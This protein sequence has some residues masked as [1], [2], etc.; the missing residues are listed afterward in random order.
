MLVD[1]FNFFGIDVVKKFYEIMLSIDMIFYKLVG[2]MFNIFSILSDTRVLSSDM[3][4]GLTTR[5]YA[6]ISVIMLF[7]LAYTFVRYLFNPDLANSGTTS[8]KTMV[9]NIIISLSVIILAPSAFEFGY[10]V[11]NSIVKNNVIGNVI[12]GSESG[13]YGFQYA[14]G[15]FVTSVFKA[16]YFLNPGASDS[17]QLDYAEASLASVY[18]NDITQFTYT[19]GYIETGDISYHYVI[20]LIVA[21]V[22]LYLLIVFSID[23]GL[24]AVK[25]AFLEIIAPMPALLS[26]VPGKAD[27]LKKWAKEVFKSYGEVL[28]RVALMY[29]VVYLF[30]MIN[31][32]MDNGTLFGFTDAE[33][34]LLAGI[35][36]LFIIIGLLLFAKQAPKLLCDMF[37][38]KY[39]GGI[40]SL[41]KRINDVKEAAKPISHAASTAVG[42]VGGA[43]ASY[44][45]NQKGRKARLDKLKAEGKI[46][47]AEYNRQMHSK[48]SR[49]K[50]LLLGAYY[51]SRGGIKGIGTA[52]NAGYDTQ[53]YKA[54]G[55]TNFEVL[56]NLLRDNVGMQSVYEEKLKTSRIEA[57]AVAS[58]CSRINTHY[59]E[60]IGAEKAVIS[61]RFDRSI[62]D[63]QK[64]V[65]AMKKLS[66]YVDEKASKADSEIKSRVLTYNTQTGKYEI[67]EMNTDQVKK[68]RDS[69]MQQLIDSGKVSVA[70]ASEIYHRVINSSGN[71][72]DLTSALADATNPLHQIA[73]D[74]NA[75]GGIETVT[76]YKDAIKQMKIDTFNKMQSDPDDVK[77]QNFIQ[78]AKQA[79]SGDRV[80][81]S[82]DASG[83][84]HH[85]VETQAAA[86]GFTI[87]NGLDSGATFVKLD[88]LL[89]NFVKNQETEKSVALINTP[90]SVNQFDSEGNPTGSTVSRS[91]NSIMSDMEINKQVIDQVNKDQKL[92]AD[93]MQGIKAA[94]EASKKHRANSRRNKPK[95]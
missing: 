23:L 86:A 24:R 35:L 81:V 13:A 85:D 55:A 56:K 22:V 54:N 7:I 68:Y 79:N 71:V 41:K 61:Q 46:D 43:A 90:I 72:S 89:S 52:Y 20:S 82:V 21:G 25:L 8:A 26:I 2:Q 10:G 36:K 45:A 93:S 53:L 5:L 74:L 47:N 1:F 4:S 66:S 27:T 60:K 87:E 37:G 51:G 73:V 30:Q 78:L 49:A 94:E 14:T 50:D 57:D 80:G 64:S 9:K 63:T 3:V 91:I 83:I 69:L 34:P 95:S 44:I 29:F 16:N 88:S 32:A 31:I 59:Q 17:A 75:G 76:S 77:F 62:S 67:A 18:N 39:E 42:T 58:I 19:V 92:I 84:E 65:D 33:N 15:N 70:Q 48:A 40:L 38:I 12:M 6:I 11:Q 28:V